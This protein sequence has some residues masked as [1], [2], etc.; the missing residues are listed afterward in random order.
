MILDELVLHNFG[1]FKG[2]QVLELTPPSRTKPITIV[3]G[4]NGCGKTTILDAVQLALYGSLARPGGRRAMA[5]D[6][7]L[8]QA[9]HH[10][11]DPREGAA[12]ALSFHLYQDGARH[13]YRVYRSWNAG[14]KRVREHL[15]VT[16]DGHQDANLTAHWADQVESFV[17][18][19]IAPLFFFDGE[20]IE[21]LA[22]LGNS[23][24]VLQTAINALLGLELTDRLVSD[25]TV[26]ERRAREKTTPDSEREEV[27]RLRDQVAELRVQEEQAAQGLAA[28][29]VRVEQAEKALYRV[30][31]RY[32][33][34]G[35][36]LFEQRS[37]IEQ[38]LL[39]ARQA[40]KGIDEELKE[41]AEG[42]APLGLLLPQLRSILDQAEEQRRVMEQR[43]FSELITER[44]AKLVRVLE[45]ARATKAALVA[46]ERFFEEDRARRVTPDSPPVEL[47]LTREDFGAVAGLVQTVLPDVTERMAKLTERRREQLALVDQLERE[48]AAVPAQDALAAVATELDEVRRELAMAAADFDRAD[49]QLASARAERMRADERY[50]QALTQATQATLAAEDQRRIIDHAQRT[51][52]TLQT[53][54]V[55]T[56]R[57]HV[58]RIAGLV[59]EA[60][61]QLLRK[62]VLITDLKIDPET[63]Q[64]QLRGQDDIELQANQL[65]AGERQ[66]L[67]VAL[68]WGLARAGGQPLP[69]IIDTPLG[70]LDG[71][72]RG[73]LVERYFPQASHQVILLSTDQEIDEAAW[74]AL[75]PRTGHAYQLAFDEAAGG[76]VIQHGYFW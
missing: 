53:F 21:A 56:T 4:L 31:E 19:G 20:Q 29:R 75:Q 15:E 17:P 12:V 6:Q 61:G 55:V 69:V 22:D 63:Y 41:L 2:R 71:A 50:E 25:L 28:S 32:R 39:A 49:G 47:G 76:T 44:D 18:R 13:A 1:V 33:L 3:G 72:H 51:R 9:T 68:L 45:A 73:R 60:L 30:E 65:S 7:Y 24:A 48:L 5:Y 64:V 38:K 42:P 70:R 54:R 40:T 8:A 14:S 66:L 67:A 23:Q 46:V 37:S 27:E 34:E 10:S 36:E 59:M 62:E 58:D 35:G 43:L 26:L 57:R 74:A 52:A 16:R 11:V